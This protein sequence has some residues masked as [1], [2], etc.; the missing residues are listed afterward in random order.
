MIQSY[1]GRR[2]PPAAPLGLAILASHIRDHQV[3]IHDPNI[4]EFPI[5][6]T[7][8]E[9][10]EF[11]PEIIGISLRNIDTTK[12]SD[13]FNYFH[14][15]K[16][17]LKSIKS[18]SDKIEIIAG[19]G[20][21][22]LF[23][24][25]IMNLC[26]E[27]DVGFFLEADL[28][29]PAYLRKGG[30]SDVK[31]IYYRNKDGIF[32]TGEPERIE[33]EDMLF[34]RWDLVNLEKYIPFTGKASIGYE[35]KRGCQMRCAYCTYPQLT[36]NKLRM[37]S[38]VK[39]VS[40]IKLLKERYGVNKVFFCD[41]VFNYPLEHAE[42]ICREITAAGLKIKWSAYHQDYFITEDYIKLAMEAGCD[43]F[44]FSPDSACDEGLRIL[45]KTS[46]RKSLNRTLQIIKYNEKAKASFNFFAAVPGTGWKNLLSAI[47]F[48]LKAKIKLGK[49]LTRYKLSYIRLEPNTKLLKEIEEYIDLLPDENRG[50]SRLFY[51]KSTSNILNTLLLIHFHLGKWFGRRNI[52]K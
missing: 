28:S 47:S 25:E 23:P 33:A 44:Y 20:G 6:S 2:E 3:K 5:K 36:G 10:E 8:E 37:K 1:L 34:P 48:L 15:F 46:T 49:R 50:L 4:S 12:Y 17:I 30:I 21:F 18:V 26:P 29:F 38:P 52:I 19:G 35:S 45:G 16:N 32:C 7:L 22:S 31:G 40:E 24:S 41:P 9:I 39:V 42:T 14:H 11:K 51:H 27:I 13:Q 43:D